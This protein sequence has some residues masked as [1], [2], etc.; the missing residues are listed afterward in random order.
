MRKAPSWPPSRATIVHEE[1]SGPDEWR[2]PCARG[3][4]S[5]WRWRSSA[6]PPRRESNDARQSPAPV[7]APASGGGPAQVTEGG[8]RIGQGVENLAKGVGRPVS[9]GADRIH[10]FKTIGL[11]IWDGMKS[12]GRAMEKAFAGSAR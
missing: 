8:E 5:S 1:V 10:G 12:V 6:G 11:A 3:S 7:R 9:D 4:D 2:C